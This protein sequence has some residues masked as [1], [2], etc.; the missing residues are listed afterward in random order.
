MKRKGIRGKAF[1]RVRFTFSGISE[2]TC[3]QHARTAEICSLK[4]LVHAGLFYG[5]EMNDKYSSI[6]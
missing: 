1:I 4:T 6:G 2:L 5:I 3:F